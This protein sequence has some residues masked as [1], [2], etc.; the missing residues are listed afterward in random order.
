M[1]CRKI[2]IVIEANSVTLIDAEHGII[3]SEPLVISENQLTQKC[4][5][6]YN[7]FLHKKDSLKRPFDKEQFSP[8]KIQNYLHWFINR[9]VPLE[10]VSALMPIQNYGDPMHRAFW[11]LIFEQIEV[12]T[13]Q[14]LSSISCVRLPSKRQNSCILYLNDGLADLGFFEKNKGC[15]YTSSVGYGLFLSRAIVHY[16]FKKYDLI[17]EVSTARTIWKKI[18]GLSDTKGQVTVT[19]FNAQGHEIRELIVAEE[20]SPVVSAAFKPIIEEC[21]FQLKLLQTHEKNT[22]FKSLYLTGLDA[23]IPGLKEY[24]EKH[25]DLNIHVVYQPEKALMKGMEQILVSE[26]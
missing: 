24:F 21:K 19:G 2:G 14:L 18:G 22:D 11:E 16:I 5:Y 1:N 3:L 20:L 10:Q 25:L 4:E 9:V 17:I 26:Y 6:G 7:A 8:N 15:K 23:S 12:K 13:F